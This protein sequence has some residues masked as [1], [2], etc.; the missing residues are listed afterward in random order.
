MTELA[1]AE[2]VTVSMLDR[3]VQNGIAAIALANIIRQKR[4][5]NSARQLHSIRWSGNDIERIGAKLTIDRLL[6]ATRYDVDD[7]P[8]TVI[9]DLI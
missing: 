4:A 2:T 1:E 7:K 8:Q 6:F 3:Q 5:Q 9:V